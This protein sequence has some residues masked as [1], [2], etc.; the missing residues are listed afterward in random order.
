MDEQPG[1]LLIRFP[2]LSPAA[3]NQAAADLEQQVRSLTSG[4]VNPEIRKERADTQDAGSILAIVLGAEAVVVFADQIGRGL[5][6][7]LQRLNSRVEIVTDQGKVIVTGEATTGFDAAA[8]TAALK[9][10]TG[11]PSR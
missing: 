3:A 9:T 5:R 7:Y 6:N 10:G 8:V 4:Q 11:R 2:D 1:A